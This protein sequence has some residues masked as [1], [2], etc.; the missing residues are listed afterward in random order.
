MRDAGLLSQSDRIN[1]SKFRTHERHFSVSVM[2]SKYPH[3]ADR[4]YAVWMKTCVCSYV[5]VARIPY[6]IGAAASCVRRWITRHHRSAQ[7]FSLDSERDSP[8][9]A[10]RSIAAVSR[11]TSDHA[12]CHGGESRGPC[13]SRRDL[14][15]IIVL[16]HMQR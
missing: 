14:T 2:K 16:C 12:L 6:R 8:R 11:S 5:H 13:V 10:L 4:T 15:S 9:P 1:D 3:S 7:V